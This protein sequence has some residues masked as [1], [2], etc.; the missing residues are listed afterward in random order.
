[1]NYPKP[2]IA[3]DFGTTNST[4]CYVDPQNA[5]SVSIITDFDGYNQYPSM[6]S[7]T[8]DRNGNLCQ[9]GNAVKNNPSL[10]GVIEEVK[11]FVGKKF[12]DIE[13]TA[14]KLG[15]NIDEGENGECIFI[16]PDPETEEDLRFTAEELVAIQLRHIKE[17]IL[18]RCSNA[19]FSRVVMSVPSSF[20]DN[21][22]DAM[23]YAYELAGIKPMTVISEQSAAIYQYRHLTN[24]KV[25]RAMVIDIGG[26][27]TEVS[28]CE[29]NGERVCVKGNVGESNLGGSDFDAIMMD[30][31]LERLEDNGY[32][33]MNLFRKQQGER[34]IDKKE[35]MRYT[36]K[37]KQ[38]AEKAK[39]YLSTHD[40]Y[41]VDLEILLPRSEERDYEIVIT[42]KE[43]EEKIK[44]EELMSRIEDCIN[45]SLRRAN[46]RTRQIDTVLFIGG[47][48]YIPI[49]REM[50]E[51]KFGKEKIVSNPQYDPINVVAK[52]SSRYAE[53]Y[54][55]IE[56]FDE[57][58]IEIIP[59][60]IGIESNGG[61]MKFIAKKGDQIPINWEHIF[62]TTI[63][64]QDRI[65]FVLLKGES[66]Y[67]MNNEY[68][69]KYV[70]N[71]LPKKPRGE[72]KA[73]LHVDIE[74]NGN[75]VMKVVCEG[76]DQEPVEKR[77]SCFD[78]T[79]E[80]LKKALVKIQ[81]FCPI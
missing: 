16:I 42:R 18:E 64:N 26:G 61:K 6:L 3:I 41:Q 78:Y 17:I 2:V 21:Q 8:K 24:S 79:D 80:K 7:F 34:G 69:Y 48:T 72:I 53:K 56:T 52:G 46:I 20:N 22:I 31:I 36:N 71:N 54:E 11:R 14:N 59:E 19:D 57:Y 44:E 66:E 12:I 77:V 39:I 65:E 30:M 37:L 5:E 35:R 75:L 81:Q 15:M 40:E 73:T 43:Y 38:E 76:A 9:F 58:L 29:V 28:V 33:K 10:T 1:M 60:S 50:V 74:K 27:T 70:V 13:E 4:A 32:E 67:A 49:I 63:D 62:V 55:A 23:K 47:T 45:D 25:D 68:V 51:K